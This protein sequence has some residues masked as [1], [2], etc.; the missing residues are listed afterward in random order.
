MLTKQEILL[1]KDAWAESSRIREP[2]KIALPC[3][4]HLGFS[5]DWISFWVVISQSF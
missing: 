1:G 3:G 5:G 4:S 2:R